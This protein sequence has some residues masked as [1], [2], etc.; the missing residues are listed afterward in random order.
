MKTGPSYR[1]KLV[2]RKPKRKTS[3][4]LFDGTLQKTQIWLNDLMSELHWEGKP[5]KTYLALRTVLHALRDRLTVQEA[6]Q[7]GAQLP[8]LVRGFYYDGWTLKGKPHKERHKEDFLDH[9]KKAFKDDVTVNPNQ[10]CR[11]VFRVL[12][13]HTSDGE[14]AD[15]KNL[16][17]KALHELWP[18]RRK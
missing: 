2:S 17:P 10:V 13:K 5:E 1:Y 11:A 7:L 16:L 9:I 14:I 12:V 8:M 3:H 6:V 15:V 4:D 18:K